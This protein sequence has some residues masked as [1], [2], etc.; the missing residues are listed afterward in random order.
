MNVPI[1]QSFLIEGRVQGVAYRV[2]AQRMA[3][4]LELTGWVRNRVD[5]AV[6][7]YAIGL[8]DQLAAFADWCWQGPQ[9]A[10]VSAVRIAS[11]P[12]EAVTG[13]TIRG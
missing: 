9:H 5:G 12:L 4:S 8:P 3:A 2:S 11:A 10:Q 7:A 1:A 6:E 13:F